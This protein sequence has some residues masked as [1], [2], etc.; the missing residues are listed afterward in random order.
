MHLPVAKIPNPPPPTIPNPPS[1]PKFPHPSTPCKVRSSPSTPPPLRVTIAFK[2]SILQ[3][4]PF[5][6]TTMPVQTK[7]NVHTVWIGDS[8]SKRI[9]AIDEGVLVIAAGGF[10]LRH[11]PHLLESAPKHF[12]PRYKR[13][14]RWFELARRR[15]RRCRQGFSQTSEKCIFRGPNFPFRRRRLRFPRIRHGTNRL[16]SWRASNQR[17]WHW[18]QVLPKHCRFRRIPF[19]QKRNW[20]RRRNRMRVSFGTP[21]RSAHPNGFDILSAWLRKSSFSF[22]IDPRLQATSF[23]SLLLRPAKAPTVPRLQWK[24]HLPIRNRS[25]WARCP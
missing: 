13:C 1:Q 17:S 23:T 9:A 16:P 15:P 11:L 4:T 25:Q 6:S 18:I 24:S 14:T 5:S 12:V 22:S 19:D 10:K 7:T 3:I 2:M 8:N 21:Q 20:N